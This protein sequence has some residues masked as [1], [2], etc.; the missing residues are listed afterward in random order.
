MFLDLKDKLKP[1]IKQQRENI[2]IHK[3]NMDLKSTVSQLSRDL[4]STKEK[5]QVQVDQYRSDL[6]SMGHT[7][8]A[9]LQSKGQS[10]GTALLN[11]SFAMGDIDR[12]D[13]VLKERSDYKSSGGA[14][15]VKQHQTTKQVVQGSKVL[16]LTHDTQDSISTKQSEIVLDHCVNTSHYPSWTILNWWIITT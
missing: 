15:P 14:T 13:K 4:K 5:H 2:K 16:D 3:E 11:S 1:I 10:R 12:I 8:E 6:K 7:L 9:T